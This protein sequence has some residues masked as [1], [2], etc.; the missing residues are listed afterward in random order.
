MLSR[1][2]ITVSAQLLVA[3]PVLVVGSSLSAMWRHQSRQA[4]TELADQNILQIHNLAATKVGDV[5]STPL[6]FCEFNEHL[7]K[8]G[9]LDPEDLPAWRPT[10]IRQ[11]QASDMLSAITWGDP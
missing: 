6:R 11:A 5:L 9:V 7:V 10:L 8:S 1:L 3:I 4:V 2:P